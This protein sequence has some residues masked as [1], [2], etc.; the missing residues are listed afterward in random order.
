MLDE[1]LTHG[2]K[3]PRPGDSS[4]DW[5]WDLSGRSQRS[6]VFLSTEPV[7]GKGGDPVSFA[8]GWP[9]KGWRAREAGYVLVVDLPPDA[10]HLIAAIIPNLDL[11]IAVGVSHARKEFRWTFPVEARR[12]GQESEAP[13]A[14]WNLSHWCL[15]Y[16]L[17]RYCAE[18]GI[19]LEASALD[20]IVTLQSRAA[21]SLLPVGMT[22]AQWRA[23]LDDYF[24]V[25][26]F[27]YLDRVPDALAERRRKNVLRKHGVTLPDDIEEDDHS[28]T[29]RMCM[30]GLYQHAY[31][32]NGFFEYAPLRSFLHSMPKKSRYQRLPEDIMFNHYVI[33]AGTKSG[34]LGTPQS[35]AQRLRAVAAHTAPYSEESVLRFFR[36]RESS[37]YL[38]REPSWTWD[39]WYEAFPAEV[40]ALPKEWRPGAFR[41]FSAADLKLPDRQIICAAIPPECI[42]GAI[43]ISDGARFLTHIRPNRRSGE[44][45]SSKLWRLTHQIRSQYAG[46]PVVLD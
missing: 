31:R 36:Q 26:D 45:L 16:W 4:H 18:C 41:R 23:F 5:V 1:V 8:M 15:H 28:R 21:D 46:S 40:C 43:K 3:P 39:D 17:A 10:L 13:L 11:D 6:S 38:K 2:L 22:P 20:E 27:A 12:A 19:E 30:G 34:G 44:T 35:L 32:I 24:R 7:A 25:V 42:L 37:A 14:T 29:C 9:V 33:A